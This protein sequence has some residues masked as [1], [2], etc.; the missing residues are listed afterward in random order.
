MSNVDEQRFAGRSPAGRP[1]VP[2]GPY[3]VVGLGVAG[4]AATHALADRCGSSSVRACDAGNPRWRSDELG[5]LRK[6][7]VAIWTDSDGLAALAA[8][9]GCRCIVKSPGVPFDAPVL[10]RGAKLG[11]PIIDELELGWRIV[12]A[13]I[14]AVTGTNGKSTVCA[15]VAAAAGLAG[16]DPILAGNTAFGPPLSAVPGDRS[17]LVVCEVSSYQLEGCPELLPTAAAFTNVGLDHLG[18]HRTLAAY[19]ALKRKL[20]VRGSR[21]V[22]L[23]VLNADDR[24]CR[25]LAAELAEGNS[26]VLR[27]GRN[28][29]AEF[30]LLDC[31]WTL[32][33]GWLEAQ[34]PAGPLRLNTRLPGTHNASNA[35]AALAL[36][37]GL[38]IDLETAAAAIERTPGVPGRFEV[39]DEGQPFDVIVDFAH[40]PDA[41]L[42]VL[43]A[44]RTI[45]AQRRSS[46]LHAVISASGVQSEGI[47]RPMGVAAGRLTDHVI[48]TEGTQRGYPVIASAGQLVA[49]ARSAGNRAVEL[50]AQRRAAIGAAVDAARAGDVIA[51][52]GRGAMPRLLNGPTG[53][54]ERFDDRVVAR[55]AIRSWRP[56]VRRRVSRL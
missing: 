1:P 31:G 34:T 3:L 6:R 13:R 37:H 20:F 53:D 56:P 51:I 39:I 47:R 19:A 45:V 21:A 36:C 8:P 28:P 23:A 49:G 42:A 33:S 26:T 27:F 18:R 12:P 14:A 43:H 2:P 7:G 17:E 55:E 4:I 22:P 40:S 10:K 44:L 38:G 50:V 24:R 30:R 16:M 25:S 9:P 54:G 11:I 52:L 5:R 46:R 15:L 41:I 29:D 32:R 48:A 35:L